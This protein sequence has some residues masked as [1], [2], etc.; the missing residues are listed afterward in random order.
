M[1]HCMTHT[2]F[3]VVAAVVLY[4]EYF[5]RL[6]VFAAIFILLFVFCI[7]ALTD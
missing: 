4:D 3:V 6:E 2:V 7:L 5:T 1:F